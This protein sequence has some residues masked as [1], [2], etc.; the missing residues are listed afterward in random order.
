IAATTMAV[1]ATIYGNLGAATGFS[2]HVTIT[3]RVGEVVCGLTRT[4]Q[5][6]ES[7][8]VVFSIQVEADSIATVAGCGAA[9][10]SVQLFYGAQTLGGPV[11]WD[12]TRLTVFGQLANAP[13]TW[14]Y[15]P[16]VQP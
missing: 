8:E 4:I 13:E 12:N 10:R 11:V 2:P 5:L 7:G 14:V 1:P 16:M 3:A 9:G 15:L 6:V